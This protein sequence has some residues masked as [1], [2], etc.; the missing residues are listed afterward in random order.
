MTRDSLKNSSQILRETKL[1]ESNH[2][3]RTGHM[4]SSHGSGQIPSGSY[5]TNNSSVKRVSS[6]KSR[7]NEGRKE[8]K[9]VYDCVESKKS[10]KI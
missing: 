1:N 3:Q 7:T 8:R 5:N 2:Y 9:I 10:L 4:S 6:A